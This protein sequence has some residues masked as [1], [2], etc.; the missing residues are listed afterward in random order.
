MQPTQKRGKITKV[1]RFSDTP[2][3]NGFFT[4][5]V[6]F[7]NGDSGYR[8]LKEQEDP[9]FVEGSEVD[10]MIEEREKKDKSGT[11]FTIKK[12]KK[13]FEFGKGWQPKGA[14]E[15]KAEMVS[16]ALK[17]SYETANLSRAE[18]EELD[19]KQIRGYFEAF[20]KMGWE[21]IDSL[22]SDGGSSS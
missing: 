21:K 18:G 8:S 4:F 13:K 15:Y 16:M 17:Y 3:E 22:F 2:N 19:P 6:E 11:Y 5:L 14:K 9:Y 1:K 12:P 20:I 10:Y 7:E